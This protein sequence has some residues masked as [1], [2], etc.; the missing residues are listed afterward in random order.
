MLTPSRPAD[1]TSIINKRHQVDSPMR[2][3]D[4]L[5]NVYVN[6]Q[7]TCRRSVNNGRDWKMP[8]FIC[9]CQLFIKL[10]VCCGDCWK[11]RLLLEAATGCLRGPQYD[12]KCSFYFNYF[13]HTPPTNR[14]LRQK[15]VY[16]PSQ[17]QG[18]WVSC[19]MLNPVPKYIHFFDYLNFGVG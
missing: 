3:G 2:R 5:I 15:A 7:T 12:G 1:A 10:E 4:L 11:L 16:F 13:F 18:N 8:S 6:I 19:P 9:S 14:N 17:I